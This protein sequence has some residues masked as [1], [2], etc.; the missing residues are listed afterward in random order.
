MDF[1]YL[2][3]FIATILSSIFFFMRYQD[4]KEEKRS[5]YV[6][7]EQVDEFEALFASEIKEGFSFDDAESVKNL[8]DTDYIIILDA[9][10]RQIKWLGSKEN[11]GEDLEK[12]YF[13]TVTVHKRVSKLYP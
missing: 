1:I 9:L 6:R 4:K 8:T 10:E 7:Q 13:R 12:L 5:Q 2:G 11:L 3:I